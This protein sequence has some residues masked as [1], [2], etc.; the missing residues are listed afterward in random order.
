VGMAKNLFDISVEAKEMIKTAEKLQELI[1]E[2]NVQW[3]EDA[4]KQTNYTACKFLH[5]VICS[6]I[7]TIQPDMTPASLGEYSALVAAAPF[8]FYDAM[9]LVRTRGMAMLQCGIEQPGTN[10]CC[11]RNRC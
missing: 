2:Y 3:P 6:L 9:K 10:G 4:L 7:R 5:S 11:V 1:F 8:S